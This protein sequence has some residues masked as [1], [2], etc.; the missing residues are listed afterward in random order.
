MEQTG[1][2]RISQSYALSISVVVPRHSIPT[3]LP[4]CRLRVNQS[5]G[6]DLVSLVYAEDSRSNVVLPRKSDLTQ[7]MN[8]YGQFCLRYRDSCQRSL[9]AV[10]RRVKVSE[11]WN[12]VSVEHK[13]NTL[14][15]APQGLTLF[16]SYSCGTLFLS[17]DKVKTP[18]IVLA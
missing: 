9:R 16:F 10:M 4:F 14:F 5:G 15:L 13:G 17:I 2:L 12:K 6:V 18:C 11:H 8:S 1:S 7:C 3:S